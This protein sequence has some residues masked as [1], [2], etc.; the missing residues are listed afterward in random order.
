MKR[1]DV[2][3]PFL[4]EVGTKGIRLN[5]DRTFARRAPVPGGD[6]GV[7]DA[8][9]ATAQGIGVRPDRRPDERSTQDQKGY[10]GAQHAEADR[11]MASWA[12]ARSA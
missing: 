5:L 8:V 4:D 1:P 2:G 6:F 3:P 7:G 10:G 12:S 11:N 9:A